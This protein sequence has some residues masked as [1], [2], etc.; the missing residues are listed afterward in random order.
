MNISSLMKEYMDEC[1][2][3]SRS[4]VRTE[5]PRELRESSLP[6]K[7]IQNF[8]VV[9]DSPERLARKYD[10]ENLQQRTLF[11]EHLL[12]TEERDQHF[13]KIV[14]EGPS[15]TI[16]VWTHDIERVTELDKEYA[17]NCDDIYGDVTLVGFSDYE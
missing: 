14:I 9:L 12:E 13:A 2:K 11:L 10:F 5:V 16:E 3:R 15:I 1:D 6:I 4:L 7:P 8:W 17:R